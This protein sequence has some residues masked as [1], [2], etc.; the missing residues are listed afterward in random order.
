MKQSHEGPL[1]FVVGP[2]PP[3]FSGLGMVN[4]WV[5]EALA[6]QARV[7]RF[8]VPG[9]TLTRASFA[10]RLRR[11]P[12][13]AVLWGALCK[14]LV[15]TRPHALV[16]G[17][18]AGGAMLFDAGVVL[19]ARIAGVPVYAYH[20]S[21]AYLR[22]ATMRWY[23]RFALRL[24][25]DQQH[26][27]LCDCMGNALVASHHIDARNVVV[28]SNAAYVPARSKR[29]PH[30]LRLCLG[31]LAS[32]QRSKGIFEFLDLAARLR[33]EG[34]AVEAL[35]AGPLDPHIGDSFAQRLATVPD[36]T[37]LGPI[38]GPAKT[39]FYAR[40]DLLLLP[41]TF[42]HESE[43][44]VVI[45]ALSYGVPVF[46]TPQGCLPSAWKDEP[47]LHLI[48]ADDFPRRACAAL[49]PWLAS[50][51]VRQDWSL[52]ARQAH[53]RMHARAIGQLDA[54]VRRLCDRGSRS[55]A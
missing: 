48:D 37:Y 29:E 15:G 49:A 1:V 50:E 39:G 14:A 6:A 34:N 45:E 38:E 2:F 17:V 44:L 28:V 33:R 16:V 40:I 21:F 55:S 10:Q 22:S 5:A 35:I 11:A 47:A 46:A 32:V 27:V 19:L 25:R 3:P 43:P 8:P 31:F 20:H 52:A 42:V 24:M 51:R 41:S 26:I 23:H 54:L 53:G 9:L 18:S 7:R 13:L 36:A 4:G 12:R 30:N